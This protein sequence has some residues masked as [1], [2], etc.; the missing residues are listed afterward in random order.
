MKQIFLAGK[1]K[2]IVATFIDYLILIATSALIFFALVFPLSFDSGAYKNNS[3]TMLNRY[4]ESEIY[5]VTEKDGSYSSISDFSNCYKNI[6]SLTSATVTYKKGNVN[7]ET[8]KR[9]F[10]FYT[11]KYETFIGKANY[12][13]EGFNNNILKINSEESNIASFD[14][15]DFTIKMVNPAYMNKTLTFVHDVVENTAVLI[16]DSPYISELGNKNNAML[17]NTFL[18]IIPVIV[19]NCFILNFLI[20]ILSPNG[21]TIGKYIYKLAVIDN[22][23][24]VLKKR[25]Y[26]IR[27][28]V[29]L[30]EFFLGIATFGGVLLISYTMFLFTKNRRCI[31]DFAAHSVVIDNKTSVYFNNKEEEEYITNKIQNKSII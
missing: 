11:D 10:S 3:L 16:H 2:R 28:L 26:I 31:H 27:W 20:P 12:S 8:L 25:K 7:V 29:Y 1:F 17:R 22:D 21:Q 4:Q 13:L 18:L 9:L 6:D 24:Y 19:F 15:N 30:L 23:G 14:E 5:L